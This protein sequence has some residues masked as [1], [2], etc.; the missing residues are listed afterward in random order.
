MRPKMF[1]PQPDQTAKNDAGEFANFQNFAKRVLA[2]PHSQIAEQ[3]RS[4][5]SQKRTKGKKPDLSASD[6][7]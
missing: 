3:L 6:N 4:E 1:A 7:G 5:K 2:V